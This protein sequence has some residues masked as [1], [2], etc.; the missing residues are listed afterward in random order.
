[1][2]RRRVTLGLRI[3]GRCGRE[4][5]CRAALPVQTNTCVACVVCACVAG[6]RRSV[7]ACAACYAR[8]QKRA[9]AAA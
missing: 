2:R 1:M 3:D 8:N 7:D 6:A 4:A 5:A 9:G